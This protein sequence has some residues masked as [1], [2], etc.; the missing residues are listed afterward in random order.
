[1]LW[2]ISLVAHCHSSRTLKNVKIPD[3]PA[4]WTKKMHFTNQQTGFW[5]VLLLWCE[6]SSRQHEPRAKSIWHGRVSYIQDIYIHSIGKMKKCQTRVSPIKFTD[7]SFSNRITLSMSNIPMECT[8][9]FP[10]VVKVWNSGDFPHS[11][12]EWLSHWESLCVSCDNDSL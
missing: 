10:I 11:K 12:C 4:P 3:C 2:A 1:M 9:G 7:D 5:L 8:G 6:I